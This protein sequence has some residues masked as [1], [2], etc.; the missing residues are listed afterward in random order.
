MVSFK[1][2]LDQTNRLNCYG[3]KNTSQMDVNA[4]QNTS[5]D[6]SSTFRNKT[7]KYLKHKSNEFET[8]RTEISRPEKA[9]TFE[10]SSQRLK[11]TICLHIPTDV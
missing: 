6:N 1:D 3:C 11:M 4:R 10:F 7:K 8:V 5:C 9:A 2:V